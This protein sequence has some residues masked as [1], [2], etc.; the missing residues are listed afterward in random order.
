M[1]SNLQF[2]G[3]CMIW[4]VFYSFIIQK[5]DMFSVDILFHCCMNHDTHEWMNYNKQEWMNYNKQE[6][7]TSY[8]VV[9]FD[10]IQPGSV[11]D[12]Y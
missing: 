12:K 2:C 9:S 3:K 5:N 11:S 4:K 7:I 1:G 6:W 10:M 8:V